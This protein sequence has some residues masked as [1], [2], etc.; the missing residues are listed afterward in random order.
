MGQ[1][2]TI[3]RARKIITMDRSNPVATHV[4][5]RGA[6]ILA[7]GGEAEAGAWGPARQDDSFRDLVLLPG[8]VEGHSH[9]MTGGVW[10]A[11]YVGYHGRIDPHGRKWPG[12][13]GIEAVV[14]RLAEA[15]RAPRDPKATLFAWGF[16]PIYFGMRR[17]GR[18]ELDRVS[19]ARPVVV[20]HSNGHVM[21]VNGVA[22]A[23][24]G[25]S[26]DTK[27]QA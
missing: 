27:V 11:T 26:R 3:Y 13:D 24:A 1:E 22:L 23:L 17:M 2:I 16:D 15:E 4:A 5:V 6:R 18:A 8:F 7:V 14:A 10:V 25:I 21:S 12:C 20:R 19:T 9:A